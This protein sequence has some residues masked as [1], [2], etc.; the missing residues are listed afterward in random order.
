MASL[1]FLAFIITL[2]I[3]SGTLIYYSMNLREQNITRREQINLEKDR[4]ILDLINK[5]IEFYSSLN[6]RLDEEDSRKMTNPMSFIGEKFSQVDVK[7]KYSD[8]ALE[9][10][11]F[12]ILKFYGGRITDYEDQLDFLLDLQRSVSQEL[13]ELKK[14]RNKLLEK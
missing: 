11:Q 5:Q 13:I 8:L 4:R 6:G 14:K 3:G 9:K 2:L 7:A 12:N 10:T 1:E